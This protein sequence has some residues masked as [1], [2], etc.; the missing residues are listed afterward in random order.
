MTGIKGKKTLSDIGLSKSIISKLKGASIL[1][2]DDL[3]ELCERE[4]Q[5]IKGIGPKSVEDIKSRL[6]MAGI[7]LA[8]DPYPR[9]SCARHDK[10]RND[11]RLRGYYLCSSCMEEYQTGAFNDTPPIF[12]IS[13]PSNSFFCTHCNEKKQVDIYQWIV[14]DVC[15]RVVRSIGRSRAASMGVQGW[16]TALKSQHPQLPKIIESDPPVQRSIHVENTESKLDFEWIASNGSILFGAE[17]KTGRN[18]LLGG[19]VGSSMTQFQL[20]VTDI[21][22]VLDAMEIRQPFI[23]AYLFHC[24]VIDLPRPPT[25]KYECVGIWWAKI[26]QLISGIERIKQRPR[27]NRPAAYINKTVFNEILSFQKE[28]DSRGYLSCPKPSYLRSM[29]EAKKP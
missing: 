11:A 12:Q 17:V 19:S 13:L 16:W 7:S 24:Q 2:V 20:D 27:E 26:D 6:S 29:L 22:D 1:S 4:L 9:L 18:H 5:V 14:C 8:E 25:T 23:P 10:E 28:I 15:D 3:V 21:E